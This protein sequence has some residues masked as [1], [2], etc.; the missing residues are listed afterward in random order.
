MISVPSLLQRLSGSNLAFTTLVIFGLI[1]CSTPRKVVE[2]PA[3]PSTPVETPAEEKV[4]QYDPK[5]DKVILV[6]RDAIKTDT[7][8]WTED[9]TPPIVT[10]EKVISPGPV[11]TDHLEITLLM[12]FNAANAPLFSDQQ[13]P[14]LIRFIQ[15][16]AGMLMAM[17]QMG[18]PLTNVRVNT[19]DVDD[20]SASVSQLMTRPEVRN[21]DVIVGPYVKEDI[22]AIA[23][24][25]LRNE[26]MVVS[27]WLPAY[28]IDEENPFLIQLF[29]GLN[30]HAQAITTYIKDEMPGKKVYVVGRDTPVER[31]RIQLFSRN[32]GLKTEELIIKDRSPDLVNTDLHALLSDDAGTIFILPYYSKNDESFVNAFMRKLHAEKDTREAIVFGLP[33][34]TSFTNLNANYMESLSLHLSISAFID[35]AS[36]AYKEFRTG[37]F[38]K[39]HAVPDINAFLGYDLMTWLSNRVTQYGPEGLIGNMDRMQYGLASGFDIQPV[40]KSDVVAATEIKAPLYYENRRIRILGYKDQDFIIVR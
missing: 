5:T 10:D 31:N 23:T 7:V 27:P 11:G 4:S 20:P 33:Q 35:V 1:S 34:W 14:K 38:N 40:Y 3:P 36:P 17:D 21:A 24:F 32:N 39:F 37:F 26:I 19:I 25:G 2:K 9:P 30:A 16:Y 29:P 22:D 12:P 6:P 28:S 8:R 18:F 13:D 15:Y